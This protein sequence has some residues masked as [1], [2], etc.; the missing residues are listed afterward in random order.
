MMADD[1]ASRYGDAQEYARVVI[2]GHM[3]FSL[4]SVEIHVWVQKPGELRI[5]LDSLS[6]D[7][8][9]SGVHPHFMYQ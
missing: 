7:G 8:Y 6:K 5:D 3:W 9:A 2:D 4:S 1:W